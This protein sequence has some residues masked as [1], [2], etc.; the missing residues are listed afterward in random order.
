VRLPLNRRVVLGGL[1]V[2]AVVA[3]AGGVWLARQLNPPGPPGQAVTVV[4]EPGTSGVGIAHRLE[5]AGVLGSARIFRVY[6][7]VRGGGGGF[8]AGEYRL[9]RR[10]SMG[11]VSAALR[12]GPDIRYDRLAVP[13]GLTLTEIADRVGK[14]PGRDTARFL[15]L[16]RSGTVRSRW[17]PAGV[18]TLEGLLFPDT[19]LITE[20]EDERAILDRLV[21]RFDEVAAEVGLAERAAA[22]QLDPYRAVVAASLV[23]SEAKVPEDRRLIAAVIENRLRKGMRL[24]IDATVLYALG[25][26]KSRVLF[27]D[28]EVDSPYNTYKVEGLPPTPIEAPGRAALSAVLDPAAVDYLYYVLFE[29]NG[30]HAFATTP[31]EFDRLKA[32]AR[33][34]GVL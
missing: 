33:R 22:R 7:R 3:L 6:L 28:L 32:E 18:T 2:M 11:A 31:G 26:H 17:Q 25:R 16:A 27:A 30:K 5:R 34:K 24:Q 8:Q 21:R 9:R 19:Y 12:G 23:E 1:A 13:E 10:M 4:I 15:D 20:K 14:L 29:S